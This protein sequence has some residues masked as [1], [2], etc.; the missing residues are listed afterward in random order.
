MEFEPGFTLLG[1]LIPS[2]AKESDLFFILG[3]HELGNIQKIWKGDV[4]IFVRFE[5]WSIVFMF[6]IFGDFSSHFL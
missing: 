4:R 6:L 2:N 3:S 1:F 5:A